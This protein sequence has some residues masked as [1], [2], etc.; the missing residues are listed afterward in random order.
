MQTDYNLWKEING[1]LSQYMYMYIFVCVWQVLMTPVSL[2]RLCG[3]WC[4]KLTW[5]AGDVNVSPFTF[6]HDVQ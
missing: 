4:P 5:G 6:K 2:D 1:L 3:R